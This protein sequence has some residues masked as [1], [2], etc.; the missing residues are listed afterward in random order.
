MRPY[1][2]NKEKADAMIIAWGIEVF[3]PGVTRLS[4]NFEDKLK[5]AVPLVVSVFRAIN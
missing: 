5:P 1:G 3:A 2:M 4:I